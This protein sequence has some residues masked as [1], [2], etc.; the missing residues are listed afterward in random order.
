MSE[1]I[2]SGR[3]KDVTEGVLFQ[4]DEIIALHQAKRTTKDMQILLNLG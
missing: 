3:G 1:D 2:Y 4:K